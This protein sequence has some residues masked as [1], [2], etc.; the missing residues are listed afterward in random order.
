[1]DYA[2]GFHAFLLNF[3]PEYSKLQNV[4]CFC[5]EVLCYSQWSTCASYSQNTQTSIIFSEVKYT[6]RHVRV[7]IYAI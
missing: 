6:H 3:A 4:P 2:V 7:T 5:E 1:M